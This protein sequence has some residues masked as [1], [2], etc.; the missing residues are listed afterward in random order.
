MK[1]IDRATWAARLLSATEPVIV[2]RVYFGTAV[3]NDGWHCSGRQTPSH[4]ILLA[5]EGHCVC[6]TAH[7]T[8]TIRGGDCLWVPPNLSYDMEWSQKFRFSE[9][10]FQVGNTETNQRY[11]DHVQSW[12]NVGHIKDSLERIAAEIHIGGDHHELRLKSLLC[13]LVVELW[14]ND[15]LPRSVIGHLTPD[16]QIRLMRLVQL[17]PGKKL[18]PNDLAKYI[19]LHPRYFSRKFLR[20]FGVNPRTWILNERLRFAAELISRSSLS[21]QQIA[22]RF[23]YADAP[24]FSRQF[25]AAY[26][27][28]PSRYKQA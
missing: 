25:K 13:A 12:H 20:T 19:D 5:L 21:V 18:S 28:S 1:L 27:V 15:A 2:N 9:V 8:V 24:Q 22:T 11:T 4:W 23:G 6:T 7:K 3:R 17:S 10:Y 14:R 16:Q 26:G